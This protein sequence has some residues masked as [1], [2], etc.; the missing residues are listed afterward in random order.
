MWGKA[1]LRY[2]Y[3]AVPGA[4]SGRF[5]SPRVAPRRLASVCARALCVVLVTLGGCDG[6]GSD[7]AIAELLATSGDVRADDAAE[8]VEFVA[9]APGRRFVV[10]EAVRTD[11]GS[12]A[13]LALAGGGSLHVDPESVVRFSRTADTAH[14]DVEEGT[15]VLEAGATEALEIQTVFGVARL[16][17]ST[18]TRLSASSGRGQARFEVIVGHATVEPAGTRESVDVRAGAGL[19]ADGQPLGAAEPIVDRDS[20]PDRAPVATLHMR[21]VDVTGGGGSVRAPGEERFVPL[22]EG[23]RDVAEGSVLRSGADTSMSI[24]TRDGRVRLESESEARVGESSVT[25]LRGSA[26]A[27]GGAGTRVEVP[28]GVLVLDDAPDGSSVRVAI[29]ASGAGQVAVLSGGARHQ[30]GDRVEA[31]SAPDTLQL[32]AGGAPV[33]DAGT[34][35]A[36]APEPADTSAAVSLAA[37]ESVVVHDPSAPTR[38]RIEAGEGCGEARW[39]FTPRASAGTARI[40]AVPIRTGTT[41]YRVRCADGTDRRGTVRVDRDTGRAVLPRSAPVTVVD[42]DGRAYSVLYQSLLPEIVFRWPRAPEGASYV[43]E[44]RHGSAARTIRPSG[45]SHTFASGELVEGTHTLTYRSSDGA[46]SPPTSLRIRF[47][48]ATPIATIRA[49]MPGASFSGTVHV[50]GTAAEGARVSAAGVSLDV[51]AGGRFAADVPVP[52]SGCFSIRVAAERGVH[53]YVRCG[54]ARR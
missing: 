50:E 49:P 48:N 34:A 2:H 3:C 9:A 11:V 27:E 47:D 6:C 28:G 15:T 38:V 12:T 36:R 5:S 42:A 51:G 10:G 22:A 17:P 43:I 40:I 29:D 41:R 46:T 18:R 30:A 33:A 16:E 23:A 20:A 32:G 35:G 1:P 25:L 14:V 26:R 19:G 39:T 53:H 4:Q 37:G 13:D 8:P 52:A 54:G 44:L 45:R 24:A 31:L 21:R 7:G